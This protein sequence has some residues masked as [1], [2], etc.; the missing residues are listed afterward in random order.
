[1]S[2]HH[3]P[4]KH[5]LVDHVFFHPVWRGVT[6]RLDARR[7]QHT[8]AWTVLRTHVRD[9]ALA[10]LPGASCTFALARSSFRIP[11][12]SSTPTT[13]ATT[14]V[15][16]S[17]TGHTGSDG[18]FSQ[19]RLVRLQD[20]ETTPK[21]SSSAPTA[22]SPS[23][24]SKPTAAPA[25]HAPT[26]GIPLS[27]FELYG[28]VYVGAPPPDADTGAKAEADVASAACVGGTNTVPPATTSFRHEYDFDQNGLLYYLGSAG[29][30]Q[31][32]K[33]P[34]MYIPDR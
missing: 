16:T 26:H 32:F 33:N 13:A 18:P 9:A 12:A 30:T 3:D 14:T 34:G 28:D 19:F 22:G 27:G 5:G 6:G 11:S 20:A 4:S 31:S 21:S 10:S 2:L 8:A 24:W 7:D 17:S 1:M 23:A 15:A 25:S 29:L